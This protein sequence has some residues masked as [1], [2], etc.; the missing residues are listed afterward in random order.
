MALVHENLY[1][2]GDYA[3]VPMRSHIGSLCG[4]LQ[5]AYRPPGQNVALV[6]DI[7]DLQFDLDR[8]VASGLII[9][10]LVS[11][12]FKHAFPD[13]REGRILVTLS[14]PEPGHCRLIVK[15]TGVGFN[16][17]QM[18]DPDA[19]TSLGLQLMNDLVHQIHGAVEIVG[20]PGATF[21]VTFPF[22]T[23]RILGEV[24]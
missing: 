23:P 10:E 21:I 16:L 5:R 22:E 7:E 6:T 19:A 14:R 11:N 2:V 9:N 17:G 13:G 4:Q 24:G 18:A 3:R 12:A 8:A 1:R 20:R 15:D